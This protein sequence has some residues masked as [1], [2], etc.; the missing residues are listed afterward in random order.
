MVHQVVLQPLG[1]D[2][3]IMQMAGGKSEYVAG[4]YNKSNIHDKYIYN[5][6]EK[7]KNVYDSETSIPGDATLET[8][9]WKGTSGANFVSSSNVIFLRGGSGVFGY[10]A[11]SSIGYSTTGSRAAVVCGDGF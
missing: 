11:Y 9:K 7:Y 10:N 1:N 6:D 2:S 3:G 8:K 4:I 5:A